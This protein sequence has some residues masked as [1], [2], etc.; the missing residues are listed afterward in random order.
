MDPFLVHSHGGFS[1]YITFLGR[2]YI[3]RPWKSL[4]AIFQ[5]QVYKPLCFKYLGGCQV[6]SSSKRNDIFSMV[7]TTSRER[8]EVG[9]LAM[10][11][12][13]KGTT[14]HAGCH[15]TTIQTPT[16]TTKQMPN[17][18]KSNP[19]WRVIKPKQRNDKNSYLSNMI[20]KNSEF[21][22]LFVYG[23]LQYKINVLTL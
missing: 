13:K 1:S 5:M 12:F 21:V 17:K 7:A 4:A 14:N 20:E 16:K 6:F 8:V 9:V 3:L 19:T 2:R 23:N 22:N 18:V 10:S 15:W 11:V